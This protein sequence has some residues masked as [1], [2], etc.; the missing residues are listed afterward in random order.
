MT[1]DHKRSAPI[2]K[3]ATI[4]IKG[5]TYRCEQIVVADLVEIEAELQRRLMDIAK[6]S[7]SGLDD[8]DR[9]ALLAEAWKDAKKLQAGTPEFVAAYDSPWGVAYAFYLSARKNHPELSPD[10]CADL[11]IEM[12]D[13]ERLKLEEMKASG[14]EVNPTTAAG[15]TTTTDTP[16]NP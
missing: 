10:D 5:K 11:I 16:Q 14:V 13:E 8:D 1:I 6:R 2:R 4:T 7:L 12:A 3:S 15:P 9:K